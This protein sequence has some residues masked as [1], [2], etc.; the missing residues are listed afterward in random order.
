MQL[1]TDRL[2][3]RQL[4][5][6]DWR[7]VKEIALDF[8]QSEYAVYD[9]P[10]P[11][12]DGEIRE[13]TERFA[14]SGLFFAVLAKDAEDMIGYICFHEDHGSYDLGY[15][16]HSAFQGR[17]Y[18]FESCAALMEELAR[19]RRV[20]TFTAGTALNNIPSCNLLRKLGF[21]LQGTE[22]LSFREG[23]RFQG[24]SFIK[25]A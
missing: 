9:M 4:T 16:F 18:A 15:C 11:T 3:V 22:T 10:L 12:E 23:I 14:A 6:E 7:C 21:T 19:S 20:R 25:Q 17:G 5:P 1:Y 2:F 13:L 24:G 8:C